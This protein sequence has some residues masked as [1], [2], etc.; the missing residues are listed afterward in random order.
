MRA[1]VLA[2]V[3]FSTALTAAPARAL[4]DLTGSWAGTAVCDL[5]SDGGGNRE[6]FAAT[7]TVDDDPSGDA[8]V[9]FNSLTFRVAVIDD[10]DA[11][12]KG[13]I[14]GADCAV[15]AANGGGML[16]LSVKAKD[17]SEKGTM[18]GELVS[19][20]TGAHEISVCKIKLKRTSSTIVDPITV[21]P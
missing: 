4:P 1:Q 5:L 16:W 3:L 7:L 20:R 18:T 21:C 6:K 15:T 14:G 11:P 12:S 19:A 13:R 2:A 8:F 10:V 17:G 9:V